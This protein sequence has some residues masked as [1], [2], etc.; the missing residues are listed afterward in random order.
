MEERNKDFWKIHSPE[1]YLST[2]TLSHT[3]ATYVAAKMTFIEMLI[4]LIIIKI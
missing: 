2:L 3:T 4:N 1:I